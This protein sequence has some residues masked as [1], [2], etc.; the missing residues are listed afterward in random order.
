MLDT[1]LAS[2][3]II[4]WLSWVLV[5]ACRIFSFGMWDLSP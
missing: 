3:I 5:V 2:L 4:I 1:K